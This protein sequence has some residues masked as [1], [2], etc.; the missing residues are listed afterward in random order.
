MEYKIVVANGDNEEELIVL[1]VE[2]VDI[3][4]Y[5]YG[6]IGKDDV[7][8]FSSPMDTTKYVIKIG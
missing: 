8:L 3:S 7:L 2:R 5:E 1:G 6:F 4:N